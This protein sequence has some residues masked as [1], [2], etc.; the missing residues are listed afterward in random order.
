MKK[1]QMSIALA[2]AA[3]SGSALPL[4]QVYAEPVNAG[5]V[6]SANGATLN[7]LSTAELNTIIDSIK[8]NKVYQ[9]Y[10]EVAAVKAQYLAVVETKDDGTK[11][12]LAQSIDQAV[13]TAN[14]AKTN[15]DAAVTSAETSLSN[16]LTRTIS[17]IRD[18]SGN[19][20][21]DAESVEATVADI[22][23]LPLR[24]FYLAIMNAADLEAMETAVTNL[25]VELAKA[26]QTTA[27]IDWNTVKAATPKATKAA[28]ATANTKYTQHAQL[29]AIETRVNDLKDLKA[30]ATEADAQVTATTTAQQNAFDEIDNAL[31]AIEEA[32]EDDATVA[33]FSKD[34]GVKTV[35]NAANNLIK[36]MNIQ[37]Y[38]AWQE[39]ITKLDSAVAD[40]GYIDA[41][42]PATS[43]TNIETALTTLLGAPET[44]ALTD[45]KTEHK[46]CSTNHLAAIKGN[47]NLLKLIVTV[48]EVTDAP[49]IVN[50][51]QQV[52]YD[53]RVSHNGAYINNWDGI[54]TFTVTVNV[55]EGMDGATAQVFFI[56]DGGMRV[57]HAATYDAANNTLSFVTTHFSQYA[58]IG[59]RVTPTDPT[60]PDDPDTP[61][62]PVNPSDPTDPSDKPG[63]EV[64][65]PGKGEE[66]ITSADAV[67]QP[68]AI[69]PNTG[70]AAQADAGTTDAIAAAVVTALAAAG[71]A[72]AYTTKRRAER[73]A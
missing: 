61:T 59:S 28:I 70:V 9:A 53:I 12:T 56:G 23:K 50:G 8:G 22:A 32:T 30:K 24:D 18:L 46:V 4:A 34:M 37:S 13:A 39:F 55:P 19:R 72:V 47:L 68:A 2:L 16:K 54:E 6:P 67:K 58:I 51:K 38:D 73:K 35:E 62:D 3:L 21:Y 17:Q 27:S 20:A 10:A 65:I 48:D 15:A 14:T 29:A 44:A 36:Q 45:P 31:K 49:I 26:G 43:L 66:V 42:D 71:I 40:G 7:T 1:S 69:A 64:V 11:V 5:C 57:E 63:T 33:K 52:V 41:S 25:N 60:T